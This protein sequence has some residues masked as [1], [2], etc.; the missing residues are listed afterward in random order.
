MSAKFRRIVAD[1]KHSKHETHLIRTCLLLIL[2]LSSRLPSKQVKKMFSNLVLF[3][4]LTVFDFQCFGMSLGARNANLNANKIKQSDFGLKKVG[5]H[6]YSMFVQIF[7]P[8]S[9]ASLSKTSL[10]CHC[11]Q[12]CSRCSN[13]MSCLCSI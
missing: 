8:F 9:L 11:R 4:L 12:F 5:Y 6:D 7:R 2:C 13:G 3:L 1:F 10:E